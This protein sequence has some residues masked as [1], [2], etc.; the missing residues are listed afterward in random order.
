MLQAVGGPEQLVV[1]E[2]PDPEAGAGHAVVD[3]R[4]AGINFADVLIR[5][6]RYPQMPELP[7]VLGS[8]IAGELDG[9]RVMG[10]AH[11]D[12]GGYAERAV[13]DSRWLLPL[14]ASASFAEGAAFPMAFLTA[15]IPLTE[16]VRIAFGARVLVTAA[17]GSVGTAAVQDIRALNGHAVAAVGSAEKLELPRSLGAVEAVTY[18]EIGELDQ[19]DAVFDLVGGELFAATLGLLKPMGTAIAVGYAGGLW[20][21][22]SPAWLVGRNIGVHGFYLGRLIGRSPELVGLC[23]GRR[24]A[25]LGR[26]RRAT[27]RRS[28]VPTGTSGG[29]PSFDRDAPIDWKGCAHPVTALVTGSAG[30]IGDA[31]VRKLIAE[32]F[33]VQQLDLVNGFDV[34]DPGAW[35]HVGSVDLACLNAGVITGDDGDLTELTDEQ[36]RRAVGVNVDGVV[37]G[38]RR[39]D[40]VMPKGSTIIV[41]ASLAGLTAIPDDPIYGLTKHAVVGFVRSVAPELS[42]RGIR[43]QAVCP[44]WADTGLTTNGFRDELRERG[45]RL[46]SP[47]AVA[48]GVWAAYKSEGTGEAWI[49]QPGREPLLYEFK[50]VPGPR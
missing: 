44:G 4:A 35:E 42:E 10:F 28:R 3:V 39:L 16:L 20:Q 38:V 48:E 8:E 2:V 22:V 24:P 45:F 26:W 17:A 11:S 47:D 43:I 37:F 49:V 27:R 36:Y 29:S 6:G 33:E 9:S 34:S 5:L 18:D 25:P 1:Q 50:G 23:G 13:V 41:T 32:G 7:T 21:D 19:V 40:R 31:I 46:L 14:P 12:G 15:W 30:G